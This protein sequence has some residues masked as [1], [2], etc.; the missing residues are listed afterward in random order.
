LFLLI[1]IY[2]YNLKFFSISIAHNSKALKVYISTFLSREKIVSLFDA[3]H[4]CK[5]RQKKF[6]LLVL[7]ISISAHDIKYINYK[8]VTENK[9]ECQKISQIVSI[10]N[11]TNRCVK[12]PSEEH[13]LILHDRRTTTIARR[14]GF[15]GMGFRF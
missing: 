11:S 13:C 15:V 4:C 12:I 5:Q 10:S 9:L 7:A 1:Y 2:F 6:S 3:K 8:R 14:H